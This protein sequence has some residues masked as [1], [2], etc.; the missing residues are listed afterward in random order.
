MSDAQPP[1]LVLGNGSW[2]TTLA[3]VLAR[4][5]LDVCLW[6]RDADQ[7][8]I[9]AETHLNERYL[10]GVLLPD[11]LRFSAD[12]TQAAA[13]AE[14]VISVIPTQHLRSVLVQFEDVLPGTLPVVSASKGLEVETFQP[15]TKI[16]GEVL[17]E[18]PLCVLTGPSHAE[19]V[20]RGLPASLVACSTDSGVAEQVQ[21]VLSCETLR[22][23]TNSDPLGAEF[24]AAL[25]N[26]IAIGAGICD[27]LALGDNAKAA[28][29]TRGVVEIAR[30]GNRRGAQPET[31]FGLAGIGDLMTT[32]FSEHSRN[33]AVG[34]AIG[35]GESLDH[36][37]ARMHM[38]AEGVWTTRA[39][40]GPEAETEGISM[41]IAKQ[42]HACLFE[43][44]DP[45]QA[46]SDL[47]TR[48]PQEELTGIM[49]DST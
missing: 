37:L 35:G 34:E 5:G 30:F 24:A 33:R 48:S 41:P 25:K 4:K 22:V 9:L 14:L 39:L 7:I 31:F 44:K 16:I 13:G 19:E 45:R 10:P 11:N 2:G 17:G 21:E 15:P 27:G 40:F 3:L 23:Y 18:R 6:G 8:A 29:I 20:A 49:Q 36:L 43:G 38:V 32:C 47:M 26:V 42:V 1:I 12:P 28:L 46:V